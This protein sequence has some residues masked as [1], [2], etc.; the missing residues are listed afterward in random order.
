LTLENEADDEDSEFVD[1]S[2]SLGVPVSVEEESEG[3]LWDDYEDLDDLE[4]EAQRDFLDASVLEGGITRSERAKQIAVELLV[5]YDWD[6]EYLPLLQQVF[7][8]NGWSAAR[9]AIEEQMEKGLKPDEL[10]MAREIRLL[11]TENEQ[12]WISFQRIKTNAPSNQ[13]DATYKHMSWREALRLIRCFPQLPDIEEIYQL[14]DDAYDLWYGN[15]RLRRNFNVF[16]KFLRYQTGAIRSTLPGDCPFSFCASEESTECSIDSIGSG[17]F[18]QCGK[19][20]RLGIEFNQ[21]PKPP[22]YKI[23]VN[24]ELLEDPLPKAQNGKVAKESSNSKTAKNT[25]KKGKVVEKKGAQH[26]QQSS[27]GFGSSIWVGVERNK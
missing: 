22:E 7:V 20:S 18:P 9:V 3:F 10:S 24:K 12:Y 26:A 2:F 21:W 15:D 19:L 17:S 1:E 25:R 4:E 14:I 23:K 11:W 6:V 5:R 27:F 8:E 16:F 13:T